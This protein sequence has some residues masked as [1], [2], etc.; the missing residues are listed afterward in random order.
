MPKEEE[1]MLQMEKDPLKRRAL[2]LQLEYSRLEDELQGVNEEGYFL[3]G[4]RDS[5]K[6]NIEITK[7][8][9]ANLKEKL[10]S[11]RPNKYLGELFEKI[12][13]TKD[14]AKR[15]ELQADYDRKLANSRAN[16]EKMIEAKRKRIADM[17][18]LHVKTLEAIETNK[19]DLADASSKLSSFERRHIGND[20]KIKAEITEEIC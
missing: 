12:A 15:G 13:K 11:D 16:M 6:R 8:E 1:F 14:K 5:I 3:K 19:T 2:E 18:S 4:R 9:I 10:T 20:G 7:D 17:E